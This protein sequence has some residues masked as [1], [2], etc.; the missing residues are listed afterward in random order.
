MRSSQSTAV[1][2]K[3]QRFL[4]ARRKDRRHTLWPWPTP[5][6]QTRSPSRVE[7]EHRIKCAWGNLHEPQTG[8]DVTKIPTARLPHTLRR[9]GNT[10][11]P[12]RFR[13]MDVDRGDEESPRKSSATARA[14]IA[15][16]VADDEPHEP[17]S[18]PK[19]D[20]RGQPTRPQRARRKQPRRRQQ[21]LLRQRTARRDELEPQV[22]YIVRVTRKPDD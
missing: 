4:E 9:N 17:D 22:D 1:A 16:E 10:I 21:P 18:E 6:L 11:C 3:R 20:R 2:H 13:N 5:D 7:F 19:E 14:A 15:D 8:V 12:L